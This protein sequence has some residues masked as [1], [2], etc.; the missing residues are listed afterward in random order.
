MNPHCVLIVEPELPIRHPVAEYL[1]QCGFKVLEAVHTDEAISLLSGSGVAVDVILADVSRPGAVDG[2]SLSRWIKANKLETRVLLANSV[3]K[4]AAD[5]AK[6]CDEGPK[7]TKLNHYQLLL[8][9]IKRLLAAHK[10]ANDP[11]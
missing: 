6:L 10:R 4:V 11:E 5:A 3:E 2:F 1:R 8:D 7:L 9:E